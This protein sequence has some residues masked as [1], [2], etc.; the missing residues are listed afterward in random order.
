[1]PNSATPWTV[2]YQALL[3][4]GFSRQE[5]WSGFPCPPPGDLPNPGIRPI[6][7]MS[8]ALAGGLFTASAIWEG[9]WG[10]KMISA[11]NVKHCRAQVWGALK[12]QAWGTL[13]VAPLAGG[14]GLSHDPQGRRSL[15]HFSLHPHKLWGMKTYYSEKPLMLG[16]IEGRG[17]RGRQ[18]TSPLEGITDSYGREFEQALG[19]G[20]GQG[21]LACC[22]PWGHRVG[23]DWATEQQHSENF[24]PKFICTLQRDLRLGFGALVSPSLASSRS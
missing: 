20:E 19:D 2:T 14:L 23:H 8:P 4:M 1:M 13:R 17:R 11:K 12:K 7:L 3:S 22:S 21:S 10:N 24:T 18:R 6:S 9:W 15:R 5:Y 16:K